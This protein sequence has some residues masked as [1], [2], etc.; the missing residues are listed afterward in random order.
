MLYRL[1]P[2]KFTDRVLLAWA[3]AP[4]GAQDRDWHAMASLPQRWSAPTFPLRAADFM[5]RGVEKGPAL[6]AAMAAAEAAWIKAGF[7]SDQ[8]ALDSIVAIAEAH[9]AGKLRK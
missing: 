9:A 6:G 2:E 1:G 7:P 5:A 3:H 8:A 4:A